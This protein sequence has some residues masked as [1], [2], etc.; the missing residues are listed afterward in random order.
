MYKDHYVYTFKYKD[1]YVCI[2]WYRP[3]LYNNLYGVNL[4][5]EEYKER[6]SEP[7]GP[8]KCQQRSGFNFELIFLL[9]HTPSPTLLSFIGANDVHSTL[10]SSNI[11]LDS[12]AQ[13]F[14][15]NRK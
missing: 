13:S 4:L 9:P 14:N 6:L 10:S 12:N 3:Y 1:L 2:Q 15:C 8:D 11:M 7:D 5:C